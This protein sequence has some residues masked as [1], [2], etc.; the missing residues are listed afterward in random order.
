MSVH[1]VVSRR[2]L[3]WV[4]FSLF[5]LEDMATFFSFIWVTDHSVLFNVRVVSILNKLSS[6]SCVAEKMPMSFVRKI[7]YSRSKKRH[8]LLLPIRVESETKKSLRWRPLLLWTRPESLIMV[9]L[10]IK[11]VCI[12]LS[13]VSSSENNNRQ[14]TVSLWLPYNSVKYGVSSNSVY[15]CHYFFILVFTCHLSL[16]YISF[17]N[18][19]KRTQIV[20]IF[21]IAEPFIF[22]S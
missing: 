21:C 16:Y 6:I 14:I 7:H 20:F 9:L 15:T 1:R 5:A 19:N 18:V 17:L 13:R 3:L 10:T 12:A 11:P 2:H 4:H 8:Y 22:M